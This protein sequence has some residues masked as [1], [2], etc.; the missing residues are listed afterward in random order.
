ME[1]GETADTF[2]AFLKDTEAEYR[3]R[4]DADREEIRQKFITNRLNEKAADFRLQTLE[5]ETYTLSEMLGK[6]VLLDVGAFVVWSLQHGD[7][8]P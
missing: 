7:S 2:A 8:A 5:G 3:I 1:R 4:E 6:V